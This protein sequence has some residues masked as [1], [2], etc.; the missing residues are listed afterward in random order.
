MYARSYS[1][2]CIIH[3][4]TSMPNDDCCLPSADGTCMNVWWIDST[5]SHWQ[6]C[7]KSHRSV[8]SSKKWR[9][10]RHVTINYEIFGGTCLWSDFKSEG[11]Q[12]HRQSV[13]PVTVMCM[14]VWKISQLWQLVKLLQEE[15]VLLTSIHRKDN[16]RWRRWIGITFVTQSRTNLLSKFL[17]KFVKCLSMTN[18]NFLAFNVTS[19]FWGDQTLLKPTVNVCE[20]WATW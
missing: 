4:S 11:I 12:S 7:F 2:R 8:S 10:S 6:T 16:I 9:S 20:A 15:E 13:T 5:I 3:G 19:K 17:S 18:W 14:Q 1:Q